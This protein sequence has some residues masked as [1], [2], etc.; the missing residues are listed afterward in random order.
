MTQRARGGATRVKSLA[1][2][3]AGLAA[4]ASDLGT[5]GVGGLLVTDE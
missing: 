1:K 5:F 3:A 4:L 2:D